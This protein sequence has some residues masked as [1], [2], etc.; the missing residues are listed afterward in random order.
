[1]DSKA[2]L[3]PECL[4][5]WTETGPSMAGGQDPV[6]D[7]PLYTS[8]SH[9]P[10]FSWQSQPEYPMASVFSLGHSG[11]FYFPPLWSLQTK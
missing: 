8:T 4:L 6:S 9:L 11:I 2:L 3:L 7:C 5:D 10:S 1:M